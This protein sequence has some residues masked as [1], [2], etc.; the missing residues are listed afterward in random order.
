MTIKVGVLTSGGD[1]PGMNAAVRAVVRGGLSRNAE[2]YGIYEGWQGAVDGGAKIKPLGWRSAGG[3]LQ[4]GGTVLGTARS[5]DFR[6]RDGRK[7]AAFNLYSEGITGL[8]VIGGDG[9]L[10]GALTLC[11]EWQELIGELAGE[12]RLELAA[13]EAAPPLRVVGLPGSIDNDLYGTD[14]SIGADT[15][16]QTIVRAVDQLESTAASHQRTFIVE[17]MGRNCGYLALTSALASGG[18]WVLIPEEE[19]DPRWHQKMV[20]A[21]IRGREEGR[22]HVTVVVAEGAR[23]PDGLPIRAETIQQIL[24]KQMNVDAR[25][26]VLGHV[27]RGGAASAFDRILATRLGVAAIDNLLDSPADTPPRMIGLINNVPTATPLDDVIS[28]SQA[29]GKAIEEGVYST[30]LS[31]RGASF[32][33]QLGLLKILTQASPAPADSTL[34]TIAIVTAGADAPGMNAAARVAVRRALNA[35]ARVVAGVNGFRGMVRGQVEELN[36]MS[37]SGW[38][39]QGG[40]KLGSGR[41][42]FETEDFARLERVLQQH[43]VR[44]M[45]VLGGLNAYH[46]VAELV[47]RRNRHPGFNIP[48]VCLPTTIDNNLPATDYAVGADTALNNIIEAVDKIK[49]TAGSTHRAFIVEVMGDECGY[50]PLLSALACGAERAYLPEDGIAL[51]GLARDVNDLREGFRSGKELGIFVMGENAS[52]HYNTDVI[53]RVMQ[54]EGQDEFE[55][56]ACILG[57]VQRGGAPTPFDRIQAS[58]FA[59][60][61]VI[62]LL[63]QIREDDNGANVIGLL[64]KRIEL[65]PLDEAMALLN[66]DAGRPSQQWWYDLNKVLE[67]LSLNPK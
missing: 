35:G 19:M 36:W 22:R 45:L 2:I 12:G 51:D 63:D 9:S 1:S 30:A 26:T 6:T 65:T 66:T 52:R 59:N 61:A 42:D 7:K 31:L 23:H 46:N 28:K 62:H 14:I 47:R 24:Q 56:R 40:T 38:V 57:H 58:R 8:V 16:L 20:K 3:I 39:G 34:G 11:N 15:A 50:L 18:H 13:G 21:L 48:I 10:T 64:G 4:K 33:D 55:V 49:D 60:H 17:V 37:V 32:R 27:Q 43:Q 67:R 54:E 25:V 44:G 5:A 53:R 29:V 41:Y